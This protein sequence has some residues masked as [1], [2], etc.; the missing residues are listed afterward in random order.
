M[1][2]KLWRRTRVS[3]ALSLAALGGLFLASALALTPL[4]LLQ[5]AQVLMARRVALEE[6]RSAREN[7]VSEALG[8][9]SE[10]TD[11]SPE[12]ELRFW[13]E[14]GPWA[15]QASRGRINLNFAPRRWFQ[16]TPLARVLTSTPDALQAYRVDQ[17]LGRH[18]S[19]YSRFIDGAFLERWFT[20]EGGFGLAWVD[21]FAFELWAAS[22]WDSPSKGALYR[23]KLRRARTDSTVPRTQTAL[24]LWFGPDWAQ[25]Q[26]WVDLGGAVDVR[27]APPDLLLT[28]LSDP[29]VQYPGGA[30][31]VA[32][33]QSRRERPG[34]DASALASLVGVDDRHLVW[35][36]LAL[37]SRWAR[38]VPAD[39]EE[40]GPSW[41]LYR[42][43]EP[44]DRW[45]KVVRR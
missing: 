28:L 7:A 6:E 41:I 44:G 15:W 16:A 39:E 3:G 12:A 2:S 22:L 27:S 4:M 24:Q 35:Q 45:Q 42:G 14:A 17:G 29:L 38:L 13:Q 37:G 31:F 43:P 10:M 1:A 26:P 34:F 33:L 18:L 19:H 20:V 11:L 5:H 30:A 21:E 40:E 9:F 36:Y 23:E 32:N 25:A 8:R